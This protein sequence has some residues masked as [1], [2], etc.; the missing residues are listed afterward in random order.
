MRDELPS[1]TVREIGPVN[2]LGLRT[3]LEKEVRRFLK[4]VMQTV[5]APVV[6]TLMFMLVMTL[7]WGDARGDVLGVPFAQFLAPGLVMMAILTNAFANSSSSLIGAKMQGTAVDFLMPP[8]SPA[9]QT[10]A[11]VGGAVARGVLVGIVGYAAV[12]PFAAV[13]PANVF[14]LIYF[15]IAGAVMMGAVGLI[16]G[17]WADKFDHLATVS[18][19][20]IMPLTF[21]S[22]TFYSVSI[23]PGP[24]E[25]ISHANPFFH[26]IDGFRYG[27][28]G[29]ADGSV[30]GG[31]I[32]VAVVDVILIAA[33]LMVLR[34]GWRLKA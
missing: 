33:V 10:A 21:L 25:A 29:A 32:A 24:L 23:L 31:A 19:F 34:S 15:G 26:L 6:Q 12:S 5:V 13:A 2:W 16:A 20:I 18:N 11:F 3:L 30:I 1:R 4:V 9:E 17:I 7:A 27:F 28:I 8:L 14:A 22:G